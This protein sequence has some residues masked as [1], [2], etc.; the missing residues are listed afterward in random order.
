M[1]LV[2]GNVALAGWSD[3]RSG[4]LRVL[5]ICDSMT[6]QEIVNGLGGKPAAM[7]NDN[8]L[9]F[10]PRYF[11]RIAN[12]IGCTVGMLTSSGPAQVP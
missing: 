10:F 4:R 12:W 11:T 2:G 3:G 9:V 7:M 1:V 8:S 6:N 5:R